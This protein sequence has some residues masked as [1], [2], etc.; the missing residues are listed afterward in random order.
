MDEVDSET[1]DK[2]NKDSE[3]AESK[4]PVDTPAEDVPK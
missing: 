4:S 2:E 3:H 1:P